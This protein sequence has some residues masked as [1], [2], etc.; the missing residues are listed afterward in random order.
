M[1]LTLSRNDLKDDVLTF[2]E[3]AARLHILKLELDK[4]TIDDFKPEVQAAIKAVG[5]G[6]WEDLHME[7]KFQG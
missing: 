4:I 1:L 2:I 7:K 5:S 6:W 3:E